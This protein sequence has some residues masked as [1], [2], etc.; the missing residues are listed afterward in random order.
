MAVQSKPTAGSGGLAG[1][2]ASQSTT[3]KRSGALGLVALVLL[4]QRILSQKKGKAVGKG[5]G[6]KP[7]P[8]S[9]SYAQ[10]LKED[11]KALLGLGAA[12]MTEADMDH[13]LEQLYVENHDG[14]YDLLVPHRSRISKVNIRPTKQG[15]FDAH[16]PDFS[17]QPP[18]LG[19][20]GKKGSSADASL[21]KEER[22]KRSVAEARAVREEGGAAAASAKKVGV[23]REFFRQLRSVS[24]S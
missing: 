8:R 9:S 3:T 23:N 21:S 18:I 2:L 19:T 16:Y 11:P 12:R 1:W 4:L 10:Q 13:A 20:R 14:S 7:L 6:R 17:V 22:E 5:S 15:T 24:L